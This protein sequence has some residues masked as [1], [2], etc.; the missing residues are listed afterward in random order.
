MTK[1]SKTREDALLEL[2]ARYALALRLHDAGFAREV[3][4]AYV[5]LPLGAL[6]IHLRLAEL[7]LRAAQGYLRCH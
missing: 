4:S 2:P 1:G 7:K 6:D 5:D 3:I